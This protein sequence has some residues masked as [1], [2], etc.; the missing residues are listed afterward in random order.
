[1]KVIV[2]G[3][4]QVGFNIARYLAS[5]NADVTVID[6]S[7]ELI[8]KI[9]ESLDVTGLVGFASHPDILEQAG[10]RDTD[11]LIAVTYADEVNMVACQVAHSIFEVPTK[12][13]RVRHQSYLNPLWSDLFSHDH[14][15]IDVIISP[16]LEVAKAI[17]RRLQ[18]PGA[19]DAMQLADGK[20]NL[21][22]VHVREDTP[23]IQTPLR[24]LTDLFPDLHIVVVAISRAGRTIVAHG[25]AELMPGDDAYFVCE[26]SHLTRA[27]MTF[28]YEERA[29]RRVLLIGGGN[30]GLNLARTVEEK[31]PQVQL[32]IIEIS[33]ARAEFVAQTLERSVVIHGDAL[34][35]DILT[36]A[37]IAATETVIAV[38]N[39]DEVNILASLLSKRYGA[40]RAVTLINSTSYS[41]LVGSLGI[42]TVVSP[43]AITVSTILQHVRRG[44]IRSVYS[45]AEGLGEIIEA[46]AMETSGLVGKPLRD[47]P[48]PSGSVVGA[49]V[50]D[51]EVIIPRGD[52]VI[53][54]GDL[55][56]MFAAAEAVKKVEK[57][58]AVKLEFF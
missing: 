31:H 9:S 51:D 21:I 42:D 43:R 4:G 12:I 23:I 22:G 58:F 34:D 24:Q 53:R 29:A 16:E 55:V 38:S 52:T 2:C 19:F 25:D 17:G 40:K 11:M 47:A 28:G 14:M 7:P 32:K 8:Q 15:P 30:I 36:E 46:E 6:Q 57:L 39:D 48:L 41:Q 33:K 27:L 49:V 50:R 18:I 1:M 13:A 3:A 35:L 26:T 56:V 5:E 10:A 37:N 44:R 20:V 45:L 54:A